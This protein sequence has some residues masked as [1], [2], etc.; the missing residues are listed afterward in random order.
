MLIASIGIGLGLSRLL[1]RPIRAIRETA[2]RIGSDN[3]SE[4][5]ETDKIDRELADLGMVLNCAFDRLEEAIQ[6]LI[7][8]EPI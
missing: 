4:R 1:L 7:Q 2:N 3:L 8:L 5:I 6:S